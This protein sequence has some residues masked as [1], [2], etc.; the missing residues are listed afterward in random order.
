MFFTKQQRKELADFKLQLKKKEETM[1]YLISSRCDWSFIE[2][3][4]QECNQNPGLTFT[5]R[6]GDGTILELK[7]S[8]DK[9]VTN[10][11]FTDEAYRE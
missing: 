1:K 6:L 7:T 5:V 9:T 10:P 11:L 2:E 4:V 3:L 8:K